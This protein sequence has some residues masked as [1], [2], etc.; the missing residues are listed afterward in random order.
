MDIRVISQMDLVLREGCPWLTRLGVSF[1]TTLVVMSGG[2]DSDK[3]E[4][5]L[6]LLL[7]PR[8]VW[9]EQNS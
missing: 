3:V 4:R 2:G 9:F 6:L 1:L 5:V 7:L 8:V